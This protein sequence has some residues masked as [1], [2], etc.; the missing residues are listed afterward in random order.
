M[1]RSR[2]LFQIRAKG[3][4][5]KGRNIPGF[6]IDRSA[7]WLLLLRVRVLPVKR[8]A[9]RL[10]PYLWL[11]AALSLVGWLIV[12]LDA[13]GWILLS[14][15]TGLMTFELMRKPVQHGGA[16]KRPQSSRARDEPHD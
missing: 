1:H 9:L 8:F 14:L 16:A 7:A 12:N 6:R 10:V 4:G 15:T 11:M 5:G 2:G 3:R 13:A